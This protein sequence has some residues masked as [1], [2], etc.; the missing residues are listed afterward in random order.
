MFHEWKIL[1]T[2]AKFTDWLFFVFLLIKNEF[3]VVSC[4]LKLLFVYAKCYL[5]DVV[6]NLPTWDIK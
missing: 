6:S 3:V 5:R 2:S 4:L 1:Q